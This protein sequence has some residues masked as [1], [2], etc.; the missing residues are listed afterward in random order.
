MGHTNTK[1]NESVVYLK[2]KLTGHPVFLF[3][4]SEP[5]P[6]DGGQGTTPECLAAPH[7]PTPCPSA[8]PACIPVVLTALGLGAGVEEQ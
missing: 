4:K 5:G 8:Y 7:I 2:F 3:A 6:D 1:K